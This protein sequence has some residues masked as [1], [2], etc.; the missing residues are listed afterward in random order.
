MLKESD[1][2]L[3]HKLGDHVR[4]H[5]ADRVEALVS[6]ANVLQ[7]HVVEEDLLNDEDGNS[8]AELRPGLHDSQT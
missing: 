1:C 2:L 3:I 8:L 6:L 5:R 4:Q 7:A